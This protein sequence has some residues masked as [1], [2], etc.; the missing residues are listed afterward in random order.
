MRS[1]R[2]IAVIAAALIP[3]Q[4]FS[5]TP[6]FD[7]ITDADYDKI[8][9][10]LSAN[11]S[12][13]SLTPASSL[14]GLWG[15]EFGV[16]GG[17]TKTPEIHT[18]VKRNNPNFKEDKFPH[19]AALARLGL[20]YGLTV[21]AMFLPKIKV[22]DL[23]LSQYSGALMWTLTDVLWDD[24]PLHLAVKGFLSKTSLGYKQRIQNAS[25]LN[26]PVDARINFDDTLIGAQFLAS[27]KIL[28]FEP[29]LGLGYVSAK[30]DLSVDA[31]TAP[32]ASI[33]ASGGRSATAKPTS[34]QLLA[35]L[36]L[37]LAIFSLGAEYQKSFS[38]DSF[39]GRL[40]F[41]F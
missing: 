36:D 23:D 26:Q 21:E 13:S 30:G 32:G 4:G 1:L 31:A 7:N 33:F 40:S 12:Y 18:L 22:S 9:R 3:A 10:E 8:V 5:S 17:V 20:P 39:S 38:T 29:Y 27:K 35:G 24:F 19:A 34:T 14:G 15:F 16:T 25:T 6:T 37:R 2:W 41:R 11:F 28:V